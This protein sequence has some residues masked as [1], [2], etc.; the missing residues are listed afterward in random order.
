LRVEDLPPGYTA[1]PG[2]PSAPPGEGAGAGGGAQP[3]ADVFEQLRG[4]S[5][6]LSRIAASTAEVEF[7]KGDYGP[8]LQQVLLSTA[9]RAAVDAAVSAFKQLPA[10]CDGFTETDEQGSFTVKLSPAG[11]LPVFGEDSVSLK[12]DANGRNV[13][14]DV[15][16]SGYM[17]L[18]R[19]GSTVCILIHFGI[20]GVDVAETEKI[21][22]AAVARVG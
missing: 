9:D 21:V 19:Q 10:L 1:T 20:P 14:L 11:S 5:P 2:A 16:I 4:G 8:F 7:G 17:I 12:L 13:D 22:R 15:T 6:A 3:C 18:F